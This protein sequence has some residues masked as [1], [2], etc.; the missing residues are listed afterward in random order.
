MSVCFVTVALLAQTEVNAWA[1]A[2]RQKEA[3]DSAEGS[4]ADESVTFSGENPMFKD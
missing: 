4:A 1:D 3:E 2:S